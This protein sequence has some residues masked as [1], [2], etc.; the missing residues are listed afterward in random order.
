[1]RRTLA[2]ALACI[3]LAGP[4][5]ALE[6]SLPGARDPRIRTV[7]YQADN[8]VEIHA[9]VGAA[10]MLQFS[11]TESDI[12]VAPS[13]RA[14]DHIDIAP[15]GSALFLKA[16]IP[17]PMQPLFI[18]TTRSDGSARHYVVQ[19]DAAE[20]P[21]DAA[22]PNATFVVRFTYAADEAAVRAEAWRKGA[23]AR[24]AWRAQHALATETPACGNVR[25]IAQ[26]DASLVPVREGAIPAMCDD[27]STTRIH[28]PGNVRLPAPYVILPGQP[29]GKDEASVNYS[30]EN[31]TIII[32]Q[33]SQHF[34]LRDGDA[35]LDVWNKAWSPIGTNPGTGTTSPAVE[36]VLK[37]KAGP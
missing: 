22:T 17:L 4:A 19:W 27:G 31:G 20:G 30:V 8:V 12:K 26:G 37:I 32:H 6:P 21:I 9:T 14:P 24:A 11:P 25:Y 13:D 5:L 16:K 28:F 34:R 29:T 1:M 2:A 15:L 35:V 23:A 3:A 10:I 36:R 7:P 18:R 33:T